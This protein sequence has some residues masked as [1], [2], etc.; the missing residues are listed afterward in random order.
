ML[1]NR[2]Y[3]SGNRIEIVRS[4]TLG[5]LSDGDTKVIWTDSNSTRNANMW[6]PE[7]HQ[8]DDVW[9]MFYSSCDS[10]L[11]CCSSCQTRVLRGCDASG[12]YDCDY[13]FLADLMPPAGR[14][15]GADAN[16]TFSIDGTYLEIPDWGRYHVLSMANEDGLQSI[17]ITTLDTDTWAVGGWNVI[18]APDQAWESN[19]IAI[20]EGPHVSFTPSQSDLFL[21]TVNSLFTTAAKFG[22][23]TLVLTAAVQTTPL[24]S[25]IGTGA[26]LS[27]RLH[28]TRQDQSFLKQTATTE[29]DTTASSSRPMALKSG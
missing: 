16:N 18:S 10:A 28:G 14:R 25:F 2:T 20:N 6:A 13:S 12:P 4:T 1:C 15:G 27:I 5:G 19:G 11:S 23:V 7:M 24:D 26:I 17:G 3:T 22:L 21:L 8:I 9:Y 29:P